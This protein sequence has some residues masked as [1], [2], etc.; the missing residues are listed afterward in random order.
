M[1]RILIAGLADGLASWLARRL[2]GVTVEVAWS[3]DDALVMLRR[4]G[5]S[6]LVLDAAGGAP[7]A[8][9]LL[10]RIR[11]LP[12]TESLPVIV[13]LDPE[14]PEGAGRLS[15]LVDEVNVERV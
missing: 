6:L 9:E 5:F 10:R 4:G 13:A 15:A 1:Q 8:S 2:N 7:A 14:A 11:A 3:D 12:A